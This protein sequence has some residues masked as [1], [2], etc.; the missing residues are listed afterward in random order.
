MPEASSALRVVERLG[1]DL[2]PIDVTTPEGRLLLSAYVWA[3]Q[4]DRFKRLKW[5]LQLALR[6][7]VRVTRGAADEFV[8]SLV[9]KPGHLTVL[10]HSV[11]W[12]YLGDDEAG[13]VRRHGDRLADA[14]TSDA[15]FAHISFE[16]DKLFDRKRLGYADLEVALRMWPTGETQI[17]GHAPAH[18][19]P[20]RWDERVIARSRAS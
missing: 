4:I 19:V 16:S 8:A 20:V 9:L 5:A 11:M 18:G 12:Q 15:P 13:A 14:A 2:D 1:V 7:P 3:D 10:W 17:L 6:R